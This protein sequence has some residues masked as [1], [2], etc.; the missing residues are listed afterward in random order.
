MAAEV[1]HLKNLYEEQNTKYAAQ[2]DYGSHDYGGKST[3]N[4]KQPRK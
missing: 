1:E 2:Q 4:G 3:I